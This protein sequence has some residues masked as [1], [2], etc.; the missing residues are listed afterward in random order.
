MT[1]VTIRD[2]ADQAGVSV[3][4]VSR[5]LRGLPYVAPATRQKVEEVA[6][7][8]HY[9][10]DPYAAR[11]SSARTH[12]IVVAVPVPGQWYYAQV[13][14]G[15]DAVASD[16]GVDVQLHVAADDVQ[17]RRFIDDVLPSLRRIDGAILVDIPISAEDAESLMDRGVRIVG[18]GHGVD[19]IVTVS[20]DNV[21]AAAEATRHLIDIG[22][23]RIGLIAGM[24]DGRSQLTIP[25]ERE[26]GYRTAM[27]G[28]GLIVD[29]EMIANGNFSVEGGADA[30][31]ELLAKAVPPTAIF[32]LSDEMAVGALKAARERRLRVPEELAIVGFD[33]HDFSVAIGLTTVRQPVV[34]QGETA[35]RALLDAVEGRPWTE[36]RLLDHQ[37]IVRGTSRV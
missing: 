34:L 6:S 7:R 18:V 33:D 9:V 21:G 32:A 30:A 15:V 19:R 10:A 35:A 37:L 20:I 27:A 23:E 25:G 26:R 17:R 2:V 16:A 11:L 5:A 3:A 28:A 1:S 12:T 13:L 36:N 31:H 4:T 8:L 14:T 22:H 24:P 29:E